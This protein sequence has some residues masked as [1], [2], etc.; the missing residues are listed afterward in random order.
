MARSA[1]VFLMLA[2][3]TAAVLGERIWPWQQCGG[4]GG[5]MTRFG[6]DL[7]MFECVKGSDCIRQ[8]EFFWMC[9]VDQSSSDVPLSAAAPCE[10][11]V[12][13]AQK[14]GDM[15]V[16]VQVANA[17]G[18]LPLLNNVHGV[19]TVFAP[20]DDAWMK[21][22]EELGQNGTLPDMLTLAT[23]MQYHFMPGKTLKTTDM[24]DGLIIETAL[25]NN[26]ITVKQ[27]GNGYGLED[28]V[29]DK[30]VITGANIPLC[31]AVLHVVGS[32]LEFKL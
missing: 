18:F 8:N 2:A 20:T 26:T 21:Y 7:A 4:K 30:A 16:F 32:V 12:N 17:T 24:E 14:R 29:G 10:T 6:S 15:N 28:M 13:H 11:I 19:N 31:T 22:T 27:E 25:I 1:L 9:V 23:L 5:D 3:S